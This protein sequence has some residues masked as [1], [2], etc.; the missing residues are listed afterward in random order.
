MI[1]PVGPKGQPLIAGSEKTYPVLPPGRI[2]T[3]PPPLP[4]G[5]A[6]GYP[7]M[8]EQVPQ[9]EVKIVP[10]AI[11]ATSQTYGV[12][13]PHDVPMP[14][15][16]PPSAVRPVPPF[17][18]PTIPDSLVRR[19]S[20]SPAPIPAGA[21]RMVDRGPGGDRYPIPIEP[22]RPRSVPSFGIPPHHRSVQRFA[23]SL[24][25]SLPT[26]PMALPSGG[27]NDQLT[28]A[29]K[30]LLDA[31]KEMKAAARGD[32]TGPQEGGRFTPSGAPPGFSP[33]FGSPFRSPYGG[34]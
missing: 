23:D 10:T 14:A 30:A 27:G 22:R 33:V 9:R 26:G 1:T 18:T 12:H 2:Q 11:P 31:A 20:P 6:G 5:R 28:D 15:M 24:G 25:G 7:L 8:P 3:P 29:A 21:V 17:A 13:A 19:Q 4:S 32:S 16:A 34:E